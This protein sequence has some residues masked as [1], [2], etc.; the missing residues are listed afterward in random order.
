MRVVIEAHP[1]ETPMTERL[2]QSPFSR[3]RTMFARLAALGTF[4]VTSLGGMA[5]A[6]A[7]ADGPNWP[8]KIKAR[9]RQ[10]VDAA[11]MNDG[12]PLAYAATFI[13]SN[14][15][16]AAVSVV[17][18]RHLA[19]P[20]ALNNA[21]WARYRIG[22]ARKIVDPET[23]AFA[24]KNPLLHP[25]PG[26][27]GSDDMAIDRLLAAGVLFG[28]CEVALRGMSGR[29]GAAIGVGAEDAAREWAANLIPGMALLPSGVWAVNRAQEAGCTYCAG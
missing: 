22:E 17:V 14:A 12:N 21:M 6:A 23:H 27:L 26:L 25:K 16:G 8:G 5:E 19:M 13:S 4:A 10:V 3:R 1:T 28:V 15:P 9:H 18:L 29:M 11:D 20:L 7:P 24:V 2:D